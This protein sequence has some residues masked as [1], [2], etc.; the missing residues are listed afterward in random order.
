M[1]MEGEG[2]GRVNVVKGCPGEEKAPVAK[3]HSEMSGNEQ[4]LK[5]SLGQEVEGAGSEELG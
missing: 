5:R 1:D 2:K 3:K 4:K